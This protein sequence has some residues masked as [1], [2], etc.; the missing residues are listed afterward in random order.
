MSDCRPARLHSVTTVTMNIRSRYLVLSAALAVA[1][2]MGVGAQASERS[3][4]SPGPTIHAATAGVRANVDPHPLTAPVAV[5]QRRPG[6]DRSEK[7]MLLGGAIFLT[8]AIIGD[9]AG[10]IIMIGGAATA[11]YGLYLYLW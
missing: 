9:D 2:P 3:E 8:G 5:A 6:F 11:L 10:T 7:L 1:A 4:R